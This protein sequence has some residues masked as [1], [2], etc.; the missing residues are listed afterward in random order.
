MNRMCQFVVAVFG[1]YGTDDPTPEYCDEY[2]IPGVDYCAEH[3]IEMYGKDTD[4]ESE[5]A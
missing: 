4:D 2:A 3:L 1:Y 5:A